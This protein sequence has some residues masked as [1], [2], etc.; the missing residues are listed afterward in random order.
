MV[1][2]ILLRTHLDRVVVPKEK[3]SVRFV[4][5]GY[6]APE[7]CESSNGNGGIC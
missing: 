7:S 6:I 2:D 5:Y 1:A 4:S 3:R